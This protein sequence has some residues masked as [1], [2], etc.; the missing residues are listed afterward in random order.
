[1]PVP[2]KTGG[3]NTDWVPLEA[4][5]P[6]VADRYQHWAD[7]PPEPSERC[8]YWLAQI[9]RGWRPNRAIAA[10]GYDAAAQWYGVWIWEYLHV[11]APRLAE[12]RPTESPRTS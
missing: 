9:E 12:Q 7:P 3:W 5:P 8:R 10:H 1:M 2:V 11:L 6:R 4:K